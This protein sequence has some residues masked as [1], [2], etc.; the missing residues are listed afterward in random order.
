MPRRIQSLAM[1]INAKFVYTRTSGSKRFINT[2]K[3]N[4]FEYMEIARIGK[5]QVPWG[6]KF[7][8]LDGHFSARKKFVSSTPLAFVFLA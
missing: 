3:F 8:S 7:R 4:R 6:Q 2:S 1:K 5:V